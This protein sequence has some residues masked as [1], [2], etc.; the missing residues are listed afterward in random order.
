ME[1]RRC[2]PTPPLFGAPVGVTSLEFRQDFWCRKTRVLG[3]SYDVLSVI[4]HLAIFVQ[5]GL[6][7]DGRTHDD[8][9][10]RASIARTVIK[11]SE[12]V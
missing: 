10:Y 8:S 5:L 11:Y 7:T 9:Y 3:L 1:K 6:V 2:E 12:T 4:L